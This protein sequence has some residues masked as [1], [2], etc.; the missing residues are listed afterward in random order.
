MY[1]KWVTLDF[2]SLYVV[3]VYVYCTPHTP[4]A[5]L[6]KRARAQIRACIGRN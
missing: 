1:G 4:D 2:G 6:Y 3:K 5:E